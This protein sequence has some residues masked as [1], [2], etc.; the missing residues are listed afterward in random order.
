[1]QE[2]TREHVLLSLFLLGVV[3]LFYM[4]ARVIIFYHFTL[5]RWTLVKGEIKEIKASMEEE[6]Y[7][8]MVA[9]EYTDGAKIY[10]SD[11]VTR[12]I[13]LALPFPSWVTHKYRRG[14]IVDVKY[15]PKKPEESLLDLS[16][17]YWNL[18]AIPIAL[19][20]VLFYLTATN[21]IALN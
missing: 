7:V 10:S 5:H 2:I 3:W 8:S 15:N 20:I 6:G 17:S 18:I 12:N 13:T 1:M 9:Y 14:Q 11:K 4:L 19:L 16:F 21:T